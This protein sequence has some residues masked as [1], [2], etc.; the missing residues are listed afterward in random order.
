MVLNNLLEPSLN[1][2]KKH[3][4]HGFS[5]SQADDTMLYKH[6]GN[7]KVIVSIV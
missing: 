5:Q 1:V 7:D 4:E 3:H 6:I 2:L